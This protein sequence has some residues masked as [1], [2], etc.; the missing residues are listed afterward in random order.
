MVPPTAA[1]DDAADEPGRLIA[2][3]LAASLSHLHHLAPGIR[4][5]TRFEARANGSWTASSASSRLPAKTVT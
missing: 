1:F 4:S 3:D 5:T 2:L